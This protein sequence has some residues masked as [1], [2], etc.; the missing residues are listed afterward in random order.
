MNK[1]RHVLMLA[2]A[3]V[4]AVAAAGDW[5]QDITVYHRTPD[6]QLKRALALT[7]QALSDPI[8]DNK[9]SAHRNLSVW[10]GR[11]LSTQPQQT[12]KWCAALQKRHKAEKIAPIFKLA[13][14]PDSGRCIT[15]LKLNGEARQ[16]IANIPSAA[17]LAAAPI[18]PASLDDRWVAFYVTGQAKYVEEIAAY[19][20]DNAGMTDK[21]AKKEH[22]TR[23]DAFNAVTFQVARWSLA[24]NM[25]QYPEIRRIVDKYAAT[26]PATKRQAL[27][28]ELKK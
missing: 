1:I 4:P 11:A 14:T 10:A 26:L 22:R 23:G 13:A 6:P 12:M 17:Q 2:L 25:A 16:F 8:T 3:A 18:S 21:F 7:D 19:V 27:D 28:K 24:S 9:A 20:A 5:S 15:Q